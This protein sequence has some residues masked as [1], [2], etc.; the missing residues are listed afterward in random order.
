MKTEVYSWRVSRGLK[1][2]LER[3]ARRRKVR[4]SAILDTAVREWLANNAADIADDEEQRKLHQAVEACAG[5][6]T[7]NNPRR[8]ESASELIRKSLSRRYGR[9]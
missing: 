1:S 5:V 8:A 7:G 6:L 2:D 9:R 3:V 4:V